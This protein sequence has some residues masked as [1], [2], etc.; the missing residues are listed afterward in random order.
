MY[1]LIIKKYENININK[2]NIN[3]RFISREIKK[4]KKIIYLIPDDENINLNNVILLFK[5]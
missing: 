5:K 4:Y 3:P 2:N 1:D